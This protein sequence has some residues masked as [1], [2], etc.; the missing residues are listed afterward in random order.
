MSSILEQS[1][2]FHPPRSVRAA[3]R[4][5]RQAHA[6]PG[7]CDARHADGAHELGRVQRE[8]QPGDQAGAA[9][10]RCVTRIQILRLTGA[11]SEMG[12]CRNFWESDLLT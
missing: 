11:A 5:P 3:S 7:H 4:W 12:S 10:Q 9:I 2:T 1:R 6:H 8:V